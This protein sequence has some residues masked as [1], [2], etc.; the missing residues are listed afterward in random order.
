MKRVYLDLGCKINVNESLMDQYSD[1]LNKVSAIYF[2]CTSKNVPCEFYSSAAFNL[3]SNEYSTDF[4][5]NTLKAY[6]SVILT[7]SGS[8]CIDGYCG[9]TMNTDSLQYMQ[10]I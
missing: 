1:S 7:I 8:N 4:K 2:C 5:L 6:F 10:Y 3:D 9:K